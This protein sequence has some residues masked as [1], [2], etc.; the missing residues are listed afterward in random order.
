[1]K[2]KNSGQNV[3]DLTVLRDQ[4]DAAVSAWRADHAGFREKVEDYRKFA[5]ARPCRDL[6]EVPNLRPASELLLEHLRR[7]LEILEA[8]EVELRSR[9]AANAALSALAVAENDA[10]VLA[11]DPSYLRAYL[12]ALDDEEKR[13]RLEIAK[14]QQSRVERVA[15]ALQ[16]EKALAGSRTAS[17]LP[18][19]EELPSSP[20]YG[21]SYVQTLVAAM[22]KPPASKAFQIADARVQIKRVAADLERK[23]REAAARAKE[24]ALDLAQRQA[25]ERS[26]QN[27]QL[28]FEAKQR[29]LREAPER[30]R[31]D[32]AA[33]YF[34]AE[35]SQ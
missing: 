3:P 33:A 10:T 26:H 16:A 23:K 9:A 8:A 14:V 12:V 31:E 24:Q 17:D 6:A 22:E 18:I 28:E 7:G 1:M 19:P 13:L 27:E 29:E 30:E 35:A 20:A 4:A 5:N 2:K 21:L 34:R 25:D 11:C 15:H 32:L